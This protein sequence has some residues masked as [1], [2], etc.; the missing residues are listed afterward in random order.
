MMGTK[1]DHRLRVIEGRP[2]KEAL[3]C[4]L[5][6]DAPHRPWHGVGA[7]EPGDAVLVVIDTDPPTLLCGFIQGSDPVRR[8]IAKI[9]RFGRTGLQTVAE[10]ETAAGEHRLF[11]G[12]RLDSPAASALLAAATGRSRSQP[13]DRVGDS[14]VAAARILLQSGGRCGCCREA[15]DLAGSAPAELGLHLVP[16]NAFQQGQDWPALLCLTCQAGMEHGE[17]G[18]VIDYAYSL[19]PACPECSAR[20]SRSITY[21]KLTPDWYA[22]QPPWQTDG[23]CVEDSSARWMCAECGCNWGPSTESNAFADDPRRYEVAR[24]LFGAWTGVTNPELLAALWKNLNTADLNHWLQRAGRE[25][26]PRNDGH[27]PNTF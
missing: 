23:G 10:L 16:D 11:D 21:G 8:A 9:S 13:H 7:V 5:A 25:S 24:K 1:T 20:R 17:F 6:P 26:D 4:A 19:R 2:W 15:I 14:S 12:L 3:I 27:T 18:S 22:N